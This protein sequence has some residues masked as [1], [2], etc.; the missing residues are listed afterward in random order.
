[1]FTSFAEFFWLYLR[2]LIFD[3]ILIKVDIVMKVEVFFKLIRNLK[4]NIAQ[5]L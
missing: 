1:M 5:I 4:N 3:Y 2:I